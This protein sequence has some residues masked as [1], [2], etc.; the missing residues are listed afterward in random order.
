M[1]RPMEG[2]E[3]EDATLDPTCAI[4]RMP[5]AGSRM[6]KAAGVEVGGVLRGASFDPLVGWLVVWG[7]FRV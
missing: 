3:E 2:R 5:P 7:L 6:T 1:Y 4:R